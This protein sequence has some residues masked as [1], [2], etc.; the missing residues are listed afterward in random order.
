[1]CSAHA[2][3]IKR[4]RIVIIRTQSRISAKR[5]SSNI[6][7]TC[8][9]KSIRVCARAYLL[10]NVSRKTLSQMKTIYQQLYN[11]S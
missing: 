8:T 4:V 9:T 5:I 3:A 10:S 2:R 11:R 1:M 6:H 7:Y